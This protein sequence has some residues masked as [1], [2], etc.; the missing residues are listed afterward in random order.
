MTPPPILLVGEAY[1]ETEAKAGVPFIGASGA[2]LLRMLS[3]AG[4]ITL[5][6]RDRDYIH[7]YYLRG[8]D[9]KMIAA[10]WSYHPE[11]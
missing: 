11:V 9:W 4:V 8:G 6:T 10:V 5:T 7:Q 1:G 3:E 2:E